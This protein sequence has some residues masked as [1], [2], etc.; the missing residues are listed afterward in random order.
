MSY[1]GLSTIMEGD[2]ESCTSR[3]SDSSLEKGPLSP[4]IP[5]QINLTPKGRYGFPEYSPKIFALVSPLFSPMA[6]A[7]KLKISSFKSPLIG[8]RPKGVASPSPG[9]R[10]RKSPT[11]A[12][13]PFVLTNLA[14]GEEIVM[15]GD[16]DEFTF[17]SCSEIDIDSVLGGSISTLDDGMSRIQPL[18]FSDGSDF[19]QSPQ[20]SQ[21]RP[22]YWDDTNPTPILHYEID[23]EA[24]KKSLEKALE[25][26][27]K[28]GKMGKLRAERV[29]FMTRKLRYD[30]Q[31]KMLKA[32]LN[33]CL[34]PTKP[35]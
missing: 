31:R 24:K 22:L 26:R 27:M 23:F 3:Q 15:D 17:V 25:R 21:N 13:M 2:E 30:L 4:R 8:T 6:E 7:R 9:G 16:D 20:T 29:D 28:K 19:A 14:T 11:I 32:E 10:R 5:D 1:G 33:Q 18:P 34:I 35:R 12:K